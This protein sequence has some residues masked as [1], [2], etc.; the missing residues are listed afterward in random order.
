MRPSSPSPE[1]DDARAVRER[2]IGLG[3]GSAR[4][5]YYP[6]LKEK[7]RDLEA[8]QLELMDTVRTLEER[9]SELERLVDEKEALLKEV[10]H[11]VK[12][13]FQVISSLLNLG[14]GLAGS[15]EEAAAFAKTKRRIDTMAM[16]YGQLLAAES[17]AELELCSLVR[18]VVNALFYEAGLRDV[19]LSYDLSCLDLHLSVERAIPLALILAEAASNAFE[20]A[21]PSGEGVLAVRLGFAAEAPGT[22]R[23][24]VEDDGPG[25]SSG[26]LPEPDSSLGLTLIEALAAQ[27]KAFWRY[28]R[29][30]EGPGLRFVLELRP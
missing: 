21:Y 22:V 4:K 6:Q 28:E 7:I 10:H 13:N 8:K 15:N 3:S 25:P 2:I 11:R 26:G 1:H 12:N 9:E 24:V 18:N 29:R 27:L 23:L 16:V 19:K 17:F 20:H 14:L 30:S 5:S